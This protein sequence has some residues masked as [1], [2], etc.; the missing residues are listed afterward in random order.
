MVHEESH[1]LEAKQGTGAVTGFGEMID[2]K[3]NIGKGSRCSDTG[4]AVRKVLV[5]LIVF[6]KLLFP[7]CSLSPSRNCLDLLERCCLWPITLKIRQR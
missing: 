3:M 4:R 2:E 5:D 1:Q 7:F 6:V